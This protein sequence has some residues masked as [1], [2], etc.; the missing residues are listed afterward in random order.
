VIIAAATGV[1]IIAA[2]TRVV[3]I[4]ATLLLVVIALPGH[5]NLRSST[6]W[7]T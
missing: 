6:A 1:V 2:G 5:G 4:T 3:I 7:P